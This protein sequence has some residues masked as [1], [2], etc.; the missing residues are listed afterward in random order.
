MVDGEVIILDVAASRVHRLNPSASY[1]WD[2]CDG[3]H[4][5][6]EIAARLAGAHALAP[7]AVLK[8]VLKTL[9]EFDQLGLTADDQSAADP[10]VGSK[11]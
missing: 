2:C 7:D 11:P 9:A 8:D 6:P 5:V 1:I 4:S 3:N 10:R